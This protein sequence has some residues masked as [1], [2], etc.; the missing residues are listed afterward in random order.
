MV[1]QVSS[2]TEISN[3][4][5][6]SFQLFQYCGFLVEP[7]QTSSSIRAQPKDPQRPPCPRPPH[8]LLSPA[9]QN[10]WL[11][12]T[13]IHIFKHKY[14]CKNTT[15]PPIGACT[16]IS[17]FM[18][19]RTATTCQSCHQTNVPQQRICRVKKTTETWPAS[20]TS[21]GSTFTTT[22]S[23][24][25]GAPTWGVGQ[26]PQDYFILICLYIVHYCRTGYGIGADFLKE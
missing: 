13:H 16:A 1:N 17:I 18:A 21:P 11:S 3:F 4:V 7:V 24:F 23:A 12:H 10:V 25:I 14:T 9:H 19:D 20:T 2:N 5:P 8:G 26:C 22:T 15:L 6:K